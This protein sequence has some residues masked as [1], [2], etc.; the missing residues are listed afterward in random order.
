MTALG[1]VTQALGRPPSATELVDLAP[2]AVMVQAFMA[3]AQP[4]DS[5]CFENEQWY[6]SFLWGL[7]EDGGNRQSVEIR[8]GTME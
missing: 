2:I 3:T 1:V 7:A 4:G 8:K 5:I 6:E